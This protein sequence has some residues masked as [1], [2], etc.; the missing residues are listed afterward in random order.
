MPEVSTLL[1]L[2]ASARFFLQSQIPLSTDTSTLQLSMPPVT[3]TIT[4]PALWADILHQNLHSNKYADLIE[5]PA[6]AQLHY[7]CPKLSIGRVP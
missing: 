5:V 6:G 3:A 2:R 1:H 7:S 4:T